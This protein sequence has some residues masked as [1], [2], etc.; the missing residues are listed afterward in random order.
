M[1]RECRV[2]YLGRCGYREA[3]RLQ[4]RLVRRRI[5][6]EIP[7]TLLLL[8]HHPVI[9]IGR[10]GNGGNILAGAEVLER[11]GIRVHRADRGGDVTYHGPGQVVGYPVL[12][13]N[14][15]GKDVHRVINLYEEVIIRLLARYGLEGS[16]L[17][18]HPGVWAGNEK[19]CA[20]GIGV[21]NWV[22][23]HGFALNVNT[24]L[25]HFSYIIPCGISGRGVTSMSR[26]L[27][28]EVD[29]SK[30]AGDLA[31]VFGL[32]FR[33]EMKSHTLGEQL[34]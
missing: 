21:S 32:V 30:V 20:I 1:T 18:G 7:D 31:E 12:D 33:L 14:L 3:Y 5:G 23:Y 8:Q 34:I 17:S 6:G 13:L 27:G 26:L 24:N 9:T 10:R 2:F 4:K 19:I 28:R 11:E 22:T 15:H 29:E 16:R 25:Q